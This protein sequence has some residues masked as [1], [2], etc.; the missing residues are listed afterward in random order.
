[1]S[2]SS[3]VDISFF[4]ELTSKIGFSKAVAIENISLCKPSFLLDISGFSKDSAIPSGR[5]R[6]R[7]RVPPRQDL[8]SPV[9]VPVDY[10]ILH[11]HL[12]LKMV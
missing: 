7:I 6:F 8:S 4:R 3:V 12:F 11:T 10:C 2:D 9:P 1:M 5:D